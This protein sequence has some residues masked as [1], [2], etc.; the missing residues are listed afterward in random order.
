MR[1]ANAGGTVS[2]MR[3]RGRRVE[4]PA[5]GGCNEGHADGG[6]SARGDI[7]VEWNPME[8]EK[9]NSLVRM[10]EA[11]HLCGGFVPW[12]QPEKGVTGSWRQVHKMYEHLR[13]RRPTR[14][15]TSTF[16][17]FLSLS[18]TLSL[19]PAYSRLHTNQPAPQL[20]FPFPSPLH[21]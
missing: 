5:G 7:W 9:G 14:H 20:C 21:H 18:L 8:V 13:K 6:V 11:V 12:T 17:L 19:L 3:R 10:V 1:N 15:K 4:S 16:S 2:G